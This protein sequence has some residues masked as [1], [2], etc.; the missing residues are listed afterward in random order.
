[1]V[2]VGNQGAS[3]TAARKILT[4]IFHINTFYFSYR[5]TDSET[6]F[7]L[8]Q[9][10]PI[11]AGFTGTNLTN[12]ESVAHMVVLCGYKTSLFSSKLTY[13]I[14]DSNN[15]SVISVV[16]QS[17]DVL[18][19]DYYSEKIMFWTESAYRNYSQ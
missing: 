7:V 8:D 4:D 3:F 10:E 2:G 15:R 17:A 1:M 11:I 6:K 19:M 5:F 18:A 9:N 16:A 14:R 12:D 13:Y